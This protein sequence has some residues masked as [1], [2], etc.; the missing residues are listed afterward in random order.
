MYLDRYKYTEKEIV[1]SH[2]LPFCQNMDAELRSHHS[3]I[4]SSFWTEL[5]QRDTQ[6]TWSTPYKSKLIYPYLSSECRWQLTLSLMLDPIGPSINQRQVSSDRSP[7]VMV[8]A[9][10]FWWYEHCEPKIFQFKLNL[11]TTYLQDISQCENKR[12]EETPFIT[13]HD[14]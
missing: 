10:P 14:M 5:N 1:F 7:S 11:W 2:M 12:K 4:H 6:Y 3:L 13:E 8:P 9:E